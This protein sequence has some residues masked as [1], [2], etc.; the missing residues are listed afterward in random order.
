MQ[1]KKVRRAR[2]ARDWWCIWPV[3]LPC[4]AGCLGGENPS[5]RMLRRTLPLSLA[6]AD[7]KAMGWTLGK[8]LGSGHFAKVKA[9][10][11]DSDGKKAAVKIIKKPKGAPAQ[12]LPRLC[13]CPSSPLTPGPLR[14]SAGRNEEA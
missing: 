13:T 9:V 6:E 2:V 10:T 4:R 11:R 7:F 3:R 14:S 8:E 1:N 5:A 12:R